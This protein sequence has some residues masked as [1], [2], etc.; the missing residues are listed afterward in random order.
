MQPRR[1]LAGHAERLE[2]GAG[3]EELGRDEEVAQEQGLWLCVL[4]VFDIRPSTYP[5][6]HQRR[7]AANPQFIVHPGRSR[8]G[9]G[10]ARSR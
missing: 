8:S 9:V 3:A 10:W 4:C 6:P 2:V 5:S 1:T 7:S